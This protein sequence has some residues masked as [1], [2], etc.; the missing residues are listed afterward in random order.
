M[1]SRKWQIT[2]VL[3]GL[4]GP[5]YYTAQFRNAYVQF[6]AAFRRARK[7]WRSVHSRHLVERQPNL[8]VD[9]YT[10]ADRRESAVE[11][12]DLRDNEAGQPRALL[13]ELLRLTGA[14]SR[15]GRTASF[16]LQ[17]VPR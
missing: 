10:V 16:E 12:F 2:S 11:G 7:V 6:S 3:E 9:A 4:N 13:G 15:S 5:F 14:S 17:L 8:V 1:G